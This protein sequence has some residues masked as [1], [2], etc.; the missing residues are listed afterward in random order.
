MELLTETAQPVH[1][2]DHLDEDHNNMFIYQ[3]YFTAG[4]FHIIDDKN[5]LGSF[6][7]PGVKFIFGI[8]IL[9]T[10]LLLKAS[11]KHFILVVKFRWEYVFIL[12]K[13]G[14]VIIYRWEVVLLK[15]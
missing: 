3:I 15:A 9:I 8:L 14:A 5:L 6:S 13:K 10:V 4:A 2:G 1:A 11:M 12:I 7:I